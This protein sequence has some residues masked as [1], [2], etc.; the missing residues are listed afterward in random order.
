M[1]D[2][3]NRIEQAMARVPPA[4]RVSL[5]QSE[6]SKD[7][8]KAIASHRYLGKRGKV[9]LTEGGEIDTEKAAT[10]FKNFKEKF[11][12]ELPERRERD[13]LDGPVSKI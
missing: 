11:K 5:L 8:M 3:A 6:A 2:K 9:Y 7:V 1:N 12:E 4:E 13:E 10:T